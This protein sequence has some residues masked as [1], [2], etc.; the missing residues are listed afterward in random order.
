MNMRYRSLIVALI[1]LCLV[2]LGL[3][4]GLNS[5][6]IPETIEE[7]PQEYFTEAN[8]PGTLVRLDYQTW[9]SFSYESHN[10]KLN[11][12]AWV[13]L[14]YGYDE[15]QSYNIL[16]YMHGGWSNET[17]TLGTTEH[18]S[19]FK[20]VIDHAIQDDKMVPMIIVCPT[21]NN[22]NLNGQD[23][24]SFSLAMRLTENY[25][26]ELVNDLIPAVEG[27]FSTYAEG[28]SADEL[29]ASRDHRAFG[30]FSMGSVTTWRTFEYCLDYFHYYLPMSCGTSLNDEAILAAARNRD[31]DSYF[32]WVMTG[33]DDF[34]YGYDETRVSAMRNTPWLTENGGGHDGNFAYRVK[35]GYA[36]DGTAAMEYTYNALCWFWNLEGNDL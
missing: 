11:K 27:R 6:S 8:E 32:I 22:T 25:H 15:T 23:S 24:D 19:V 14:P 33:T 30:G 7:I 12:T 10:Q 26:N 20:H 17:T 35:Q 2:P 28:T 3:S 16:Y 18:P 36:H 5:N 29:I 31:P 34:A 21:Y 13:Y 1:F 9:E 4:E